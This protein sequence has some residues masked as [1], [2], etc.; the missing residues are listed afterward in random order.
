MEKGLSFQNGDETT[1]S[2]FQ[3]KNL[4]T[5]LLPFTKI[6]SKGITDQM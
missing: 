4:E 1:T 3:K 5:D 6:N 2:T